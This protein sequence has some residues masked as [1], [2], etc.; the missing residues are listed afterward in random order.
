MAD[1]FDD[2]GDI[3][4]LVSNW[5]TSGQIRYFSNAGKS[6]K[7]G[8]ITFN[9]CTETAGLVGIFGGLNLVQADYDND[10]RLDVLVLRGAWLDDKGHHPNSLLRNV[11]EGGCVQD[12]VDAFA[13]SG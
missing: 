8:Q 5:N 2:D 6:E 1:D 4:L 7:D 11:G 3:D 10:G 13:L 9:D 12:P